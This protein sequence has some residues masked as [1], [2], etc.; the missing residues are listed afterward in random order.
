MKT[1]KLFSRTIAIFGV[2]MMLAVSGWSAADLSITKIVDNATPTVGDNVTFTIV[3]T[4]NGP[5]TSDVTITDTLPAGL[6]WVSDSDNGKNNFSCANSGNAVTCT[7]SENFTTNETVTITIVATVTA[8]GTITNTA[9]IASANA[10]A[11]N[12]NAN[13]SASVALTATVPSADLSIT[14]IVDNATPTVGDNVTF[15]IIGTN[16]GPITSDVTITDTLPAGLTWVSDSENKSNF[17]CTNSGNAVT[18]AG[19]ENFTTNET[20]TITIVATVTA[21]GTIT[22]TANITS[23]NAVADNNNANNSASVA[24]T[25]NLPNADVSMTKTAPAAVTEGASLAYTLT[26]RNNSTT[27]NTSS[28]QVVDTLPM[29]VGYVSGSGT[30]WSCGAVGQIVTCNLSGNLNASTTAGVLTINTTAP[31]TIPSPNP[32][33]NTATVTSAANDPTPANNTAT[34]TTTVNVVQVGWEQATYETAENTALVYGQSSQMPMRIVLDHAVAY[35]VSV[36]YQTYNGTAIGDVDYR[37]AGGTVTIPAGENNVTVNMDIYHDEAI[38]LAENFTVVLS[39]PTGSGG[40]LL[41]TDRTTA[42]VTITEQT[43]APM[44]YSDSFNAV[45]LDGTWRTLFSSGGFTPQTVNNRLRMTPATGNIATAVTKDY[46]FRA[47]QNLIITEFTHYAYGGTGADGISLVLYDSAVGATPTVGAFGGSLGYAQKSNPGSDCTVAGGCPGFQGGWLG[48]GIDEYGNYSNPTEGRLGSGTNSGFRNDAVAIRGQ[49]I[50]QDGYTFLAG[51]GTLTPSIDSA[52][53]TPN[54]GDKFRMTVDAR[55]PA[56]LYISLERNTGSGYVFIINKFD[57]IASQGVSPAFVRL[58]LTGSTGGSTN[59]HEIDDITVW[60]RCTPYN[61]TPPVPPENIGAVDVVDN[62]PT[63]GYTAQ[64]GLKTKITTEP[65]KTLDAVWL[66]TTGGFTAIPYYTAGNNNVVDMP[67]LFYVSDTNSTDDNGVCTTERYQLMGANGSPLVATFH[68]GDTYA[69]STSTYTVQANAKQYSK[70]VQKYLNFY[71]MNLIDPSIT[72]LV[73]SS[74]NGNI[75][76]MPQCAN[77]GNQYLQAFGQVAVDRCRS[78]IN[79]APCEPNNHGVGTGEYNHNYGCY[80]CTLDAL[81]T[82]GC[83]SDAFAIRPDKFAIN[84]SHTDMPNLLRAGQDYNTS[85]D[86]YNYNTSTNTQDYNV[87]SANSVFSVITTKYNRNNVVTPSMAGTA[88]FG[89]SDFNI[90][91]GLSVKSGVAGYEVAGLSFNDV[92]KITLSVQ[93]QNW[94]NVD[95]DDTTGDCTGRYVCGDKN[96]TFIP[97]HFDFNELNITNNNGNPGSFTYIANE[98]GQM[99]GRIHTQVR[100]LNKDGNVT[101]NFATF[102]LW[103][104]NINIIPVVR[105]SVY[106]YPDANETTITNLALGFSAGTKTIPWN[107]TNTSQYLRF[108]FQRDRNQTANSFDVLGTD[109]NIS[110][111]STYIDGGNQANINGTGNGTASGSSKFVYGR[112]IPRDVRVFGSVPYTA[113]AWYEVFNTLTIG[114]TTLAPSRNES[115]WHINTLHSDAS[116]GDGNVTRISSSAVN[117]SST[118]ASGV[119]SYNFSASGT[120]PYSAKAHIDT[121]PW[122][123]YGQNVSPYSDPSAI[124]LDCFTHPCFNIN[125]VPAVGATGS[126][127]TESEATKGSKRSTGGAGGWKSTRDYAPAIR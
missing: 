49:G 24:L 109:L 34:A 122:L 98:V 107:E 100:A 86:A 21:A 74:N 83:S 60:G 20:V 3:G 123:W 95:I 65:L 76:G 17:S 41:R 23:A 126:A 85:I 27:I 57:A 58:A 4:N 105:K 92:G 97:E 42:P 32:M 13:N 108:N 116:D 96:L 36:T 52:G 29:G 6:T 9:N 114:G 106:L 119:E 18:C 118:S 14:K 72:C 46:E 78:T 47:S 70:I 75:A 110:A 77:S 90:S 120:V 39:S 91:D 104:N 55:D 15:T 44:C 12:N 121:D 111:S 73:N 11:D 124:N 16:N 67:V 81:A 33:T 25:V 37:I 84:S 115:I 82:K 88:V 28:V 50:G 117:M 80:Q 125:V 48:L 87:T 63:N 22:N 99:S 64:T 2:A 31:S 113:N 89:S 5:T 79:G 51:T 103:E 30:N 66:G 38:E 69:R 61:P 19:S 62:Y 102:P 94:S 112:I 26:V 8:A 1:F 93:D 101:Q 53:S 68:A 127:K 7:G 54:P 10:V 45:S 56:H 59:I 71:G 40:V 35:P 43:T